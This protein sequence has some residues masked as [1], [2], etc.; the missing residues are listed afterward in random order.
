MNKIFEAILFV[1]FMSLVMN[2]YENSHV[3]T[4]FGLAVIS[5]KDFSYAGCNSGLD[6]R[7][8]SLC[9]WADQTIKYYDKQCDGCLIKKNS[10]RQIF[11][12]FDPLGNKILGFSDM[13]DESCNVSLQKAYFWESD[14]VEFRTTLFHEIG[15]CIGFMHEDK[16]SSIMYF[17]SDPSITDKTVLEFVKGRMKERLTKGF[18]FLNI[19]FIK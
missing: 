7:D 19:T 1:S 11:I 14:P 13:K 5:A 15:H 3:M 9:D 6:S 4:Q 16:K 10:K 17:E 18:V 12:S 8:R 2:A